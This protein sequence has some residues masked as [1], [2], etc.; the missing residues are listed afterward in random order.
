MWGKQLK[1]N[2]SLSMGFLGNFAL[3]Q[4]EC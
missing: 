3:Q 1:H 2:A 4:A